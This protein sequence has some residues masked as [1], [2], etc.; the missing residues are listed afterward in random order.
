MMF[1]SAYMVFLLFRHH[2]R[3]LH[4][5]RSILSIRHSPEQRATWTILAL[6]QEG[7]HPNRL[8]PKNPVHAEETSPSV[9]V[10]GFSER[11]RAS[12]I[13]RIRPQSEN[14]AGLRA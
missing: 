1:S 12:H 3:S 4:L 13:Q 5:H 6:V 9:I 11:L 10:D 7:E 14:L 2:R 8:D